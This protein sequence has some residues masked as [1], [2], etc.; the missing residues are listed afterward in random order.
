[1]NFT[2]LSIVLA[3]AQ[4]LMQVVFKSISDKKMEQSSKEILFTCVSKIDGRRRYK[5]ILL[6]DRNFAAQLK[7][8]IEG[9]SL[10][11]SV[12]VNTVTGSILVTYSCDEKNIDEIF[13]H[14]NEQAMKV[15]AQKA[16][17]DDSLFSKFSRSAFSAASA[18][19]VGNEASKLG[20]RSAIGRYLNQYASTAN[21]F[22]KSS[23]AGIADLSILIGA[24]CLIWGG[25]KI[26]SQNQVPNGPQ[27][28]WWGYRILEGGSR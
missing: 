22:V 14:I 18:Y 25:Y 7:S 27:M 19:S 3:L 16:A 17:D 12:T 23:T 26:F 6:K 24:V 28:L 9:L 4:P 1:M 5:S 21:N 10:A 20:K 2:V 8:K 11:E 13:E 15:S